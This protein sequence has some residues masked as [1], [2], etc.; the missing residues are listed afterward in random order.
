MTKNP[1]STENELIRK[2]AKYKDWRRKIFVRDD[3]TCTECGV[4][5]SKELRIELNAH[6]IKKFF[7]CPDHRFDVDNGTTLC[8]DC[9][10]LEHTGGKAEL[11]T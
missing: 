9:H 2:S 1:I 4:R 11:I 3:F 7:E 6:H 5:S 8:I 10:K